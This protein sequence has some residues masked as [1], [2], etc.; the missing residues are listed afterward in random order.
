MLLQHPAL[1]NNAWMLPSNLCNRTSDEKQAGI[2]MDGGKHQMAC[3]QHGQ[4]MNAAPQ[5]N[6]SIDRQSAARC[7]PTSN[8][9]PPSCTYCRCTGP[10]ASEK[11]LL[12]MAQTPCYTTDRTVESWAAQELRG[13]PCL[14]AH[15]SISSQLQSSTDTHIQQLKDIYRHML[16]APAN[17][18][19]TPACSSQGAHARPRRMA[20]C[21]FN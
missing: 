11:L 10:I 9:K 3:L 13:T 8:S 6:P 19:T 18:A 17:K 14:N 16:F 15:V 1:P 2:A 20:F 12:N 5:C 7:C 4:S 21:I